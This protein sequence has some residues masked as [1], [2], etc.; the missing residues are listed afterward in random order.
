MSNL[1]NAII[2]YKQ[3]AI[4]DI[5]H[6]PDLVRVINP[7][8]QDAEDLIYKNVFP[9]FRV[10]T[11]DSETLTYLTVCVSYPEAYHPEDF[12]RAVNLSICIICHQDEM[13]TDFGATKLDYIGSKLDDIFL[14]S[15]KYGFGQVY[16]L[17]SIESS[18]DQFHRY[19]ELVY[20]TTETRVN[21][22]G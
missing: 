10:P 6:N 8:V 11:I 14:N 7:D 9:F 2:D 19:R 12:K 16:L 18:L 21:C 22:G 5:I 3:D 4:A 20:R 13:L 15:N 17:S 1:H